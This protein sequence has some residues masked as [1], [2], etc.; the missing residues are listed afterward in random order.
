[1]A[2]FDKL[3]VG[4]GK[5]TA[6]TPVPGAVPASTGVAVAPAA[7]GTARQ[8]NGLK[9]FLWLT[10]DFRGGNL[11]DLGRVAQST[12]NFFAERGFKVYTEDVLA[13]W[14]DHMEQE[15]ARLRKTAGANSPEEEPEFNPAAITE[16]FLKANLDYPHGTFHAVLL[17]D[18]LDYFETVQQ[19]VVVERVAALLKPGGVVLGMF[20]SRRPEAFYRYRV[21]GAESIEMVSVPPLLAHAHVFQNRDLMNLFRGFRSSKTFV[22]RD[23]IREAVFLR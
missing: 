19:P 2:L 8:S 21:V 7:D 9:D 15:E 12:V 4:N 3:R 20:H 16:R 6:Q 5:A 10:S 14:K 18:V 13:S 11:L 1:M 22:G 23:Q 17:W